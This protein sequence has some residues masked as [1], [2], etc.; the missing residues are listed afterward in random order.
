MRQEAK[1]AAKNSAVWRL[2][3]QNELYHCQVMPEYDKKTVWRIVG[4]DSS[5]KAG[6]NFEQHDKL[7]KLRQAK[8]CTLC[9]LNSTPLV[10]AY[11]LP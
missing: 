9:K 11:I 10:S 6:A 7:V 3:A 8:S 5:S 1:R 4:A 2:S